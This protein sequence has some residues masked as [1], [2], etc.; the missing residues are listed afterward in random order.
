M[1]AGSGHC[2]DQRRKAGGE[3]LKWGEPEKLRLRDFLTTSVLPWFPC[4]D[5]NSGSV[6]DV[7]N[8]YLFE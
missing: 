7:C 1:E 8:G 6:L 5:W 4:S 2:E 3:K